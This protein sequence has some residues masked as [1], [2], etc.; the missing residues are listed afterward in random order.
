MVF[1]LG[2]ANTQAKSSLSDN[3]LIT[4]FDKPEPKKK[5]DSGKKKKAKK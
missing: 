1:S 5:K 4:I 2:D 3:D